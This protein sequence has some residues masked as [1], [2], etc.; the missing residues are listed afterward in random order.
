MVGVIDY[1]LLRI[2]DVVDDKVAFV[3]GDDSLAVGSTEGGSLHDGHTS[4]P[5][6]EGDAVLHVYSC[7]VFHTRR[8]NFFEVVSE[9]HEGE[10][11][12]VYTQIIQGSAAQFQTHNPF[13][14]GDG[15]TQAG[16]QHHRF[17]DDAAFCQFADGPGERHVACP[18]SFGQEYL[19]FLRYSYQFFGFTGIGGE[20]F[21]AQYRFPFEQAHP[22]RSEVV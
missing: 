4:V 6:G 14:V 9:C 1:G 12:G 8:G 21:L 19:F 15:I 18:D 20:C 3:A 13:F 5:I 22:G 11:D 10:V 17:S 16:R 7:L 2:V